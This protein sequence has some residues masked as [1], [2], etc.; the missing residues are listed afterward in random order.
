[1]CVHACVRVRVCVCQ[2]WIQ[3]VIFKIVILC[4]G[5]SLVDFGSV[6]LTPIL[7]LLHFFLVFLVI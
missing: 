5:Q 3:T 6:A 2:S 7:I 4:F 1:V